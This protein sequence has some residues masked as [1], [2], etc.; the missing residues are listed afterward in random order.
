[1]FGAASP[2]TVQLPKWQVLIFLPQAASENILVFSVK[3][4]LTK[5]QNPAV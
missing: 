1:M 4:R 5:T 3:F 2:S